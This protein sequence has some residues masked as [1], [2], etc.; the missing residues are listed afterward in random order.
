MK[1]DIRKLVIYRNLQY[2]ELF[3]DMAAL[4]GFAEREKET[5]PFDCA[6]RAGCAVWL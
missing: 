2:G 6:D 3:F 1:T 5:D 4:M